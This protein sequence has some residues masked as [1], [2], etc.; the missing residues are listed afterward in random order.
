L[1]SG[2]RVMNGRGTVL[3]FGHRALLQTLIEKGALFRG[4]IFGG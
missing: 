1:V 4:S 3:S 2:R